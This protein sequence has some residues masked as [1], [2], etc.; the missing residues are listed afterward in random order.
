LEYLKDRIRAVAA[1]GLVGE[2]V[3][4]EISPSLLGVLR[5]GNTEKGVKVGGRE[6]RI[7]KRG[8]E[9]ISDVLSRREGGIAEVNL[10]KQ[11]CS[12]LCTHKQT[13]VLFST[14]LRSLYEVIYQCEAV[15]IF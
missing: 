13:P 5:Q 11:P 6:G 15:F 8:H 10:F 7:R 3:V 4:A 12:E 9:E 14:A 1:I 2:R